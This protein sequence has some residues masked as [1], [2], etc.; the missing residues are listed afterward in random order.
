V[1][2]VVVSLS[3]PAVV[4]FQLQDVA[5]PRIAGVT[6]MTHVPAPGPFP[7]EATITDPSTVAEAALV[8]RIAHGSWIETPMSRDGDLY[9]ALIPQASP[10][11]TCR[12][13]VRARDG[14]GL[15]STSPP[16]APGSSWSF[17][18]TSIFYAYDAETQGSPPWIIGAPGDHGSRGVWVREDPT[19][20]LFGADPVKPEDDHT[21]PPGVQCFVTGHGT[22]Y[23][24][25]T[26]T[27]VQ[28]PLFN[29]SACSAAWISYWRWY[30]LI[31]MTPGSSEVFEVKVSNDGGLTWATLERLAAMEN[32]WRGMDLRVDTVVP[33]T[34][35]M[36]FRFVASENDGDT[37]VIAALDDVS[38]E[39]VPSGSSGVGSPDGAPELAL[40]PIGAVAARGDVAIRFSLDR[41]APARLD[42]FDVSGRLVRRLLDGPRPAGWQTVLWDGRARSGAAAP[43]GIYFCRLECG[44]RSLVR[45]IV[46]IE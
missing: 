29:L 3:Q 10:G 1:D 12:Y 18:V 44:R 14:A 41:A 45:K 38:I 31:Q 19:G 25:A 7:I 32:S 28:S 26:L 11:D 13:Y 30:A 16:D 17:V 21:P 4:D 5:G 42:L 33:L 23:L 43:S 34:D 9:R 15:E 20:M 6:T 40:R 35:R 2:N 39:V 22:S 24:N 8:Y 37:F 27:T 46:L 36:L